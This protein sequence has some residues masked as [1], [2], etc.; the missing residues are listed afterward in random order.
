M[1]MAGVFIYF[2]KSKIVYP[3]PLKPGE[4][5]EILYIEGEVLSVGGGED[6]KY[7]DVTFLYKK[8]GDVFVTSKKKISAMRG[9]K[10]FVMDDGRLKKEE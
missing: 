9:G 6:T 4:L 8:G 3:R 7:K 10:Y 2:A 5:I 1:L